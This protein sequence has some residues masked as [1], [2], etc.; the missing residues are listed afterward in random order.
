MAGR[1]HAVLRA[2]ADDLPAALAFLE[3]A[4]INHARLP[5]PLEEART[6]TLYAN[7]LRRRGH[8]GDARREY[9]APRVVFIRLG[10]PIQAARVAVELA[11]LGG[12]TAAGGLTGVEEH[13]AALTGAGATN[14]EW[15][16][17][18]S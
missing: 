5:M 2:A 12:R 15:P 8:R 4:L 9:E 7:L 6:R 10:T 16:P 1:C 14:R 13:V 17:S 18:C 3:S 11:S